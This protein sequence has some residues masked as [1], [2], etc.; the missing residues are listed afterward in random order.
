MDVE[1]ALTKYSVGSDGCC[2]ETLKR[3]ARLGVGASRVEVTFQDL[4]PCAEATDHCSYQLSWRGQT[5]LFGS[6]PVK[7]SGET[8]VR[9]ADID[10][11]E[12]RVLSGRIQVEDAKPYQQAFLK[13]TNVDLPKGS[14]QI[15]ILAGGTFSFVGVPAVGSVQWEF[16]SLHQDLMKVVGEWDGEPQILIEVRAAEEIRGCLM[17]SGRSVAGASVQLSYASWPRGPIEVGSEGSGGDGCFRLLHDRDVPA[18]LRIYFGPTGRFWM[19]LPDI[20]PGGT[21]G[22]LDLGM[23]ELSER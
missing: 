9:L 18:E 6:M 19:R 23:I 4:Q 11:R 15:P 5:T 1:I 17:L 10:V 2:E 16:Q 8:Q 21:T 7:L 13:L 20:E 14:V 22:T 3:T 12:G